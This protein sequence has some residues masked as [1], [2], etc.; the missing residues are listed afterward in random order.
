MFKTVKLSH[1]GT[2]KKF[3]LPWIYLFSTWGNMILALM[4]IFIK[5]VLRYYVTHKILPLICRGLVKEKYLL[6]IWGFFFL[7]K[8]ICCGYSLEVPHWGTSNEYPQHMDLRRNWENYLRIIFKYSSITSLLLFDLSYG[9]ELASLSEETPWLFK[10]TA[11]ISVSF[12]LLLWNT[13]I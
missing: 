3:K 2:Q 11:C 8:I 6:I 9:S 5:T 12:Y 13:H 4:D 10:E 1:K 7:C